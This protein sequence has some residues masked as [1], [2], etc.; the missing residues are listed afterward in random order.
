MSPWPGQWGSLVLALDVR[1]LS[2]RIVLEL[3]SLSLRIVLE[4][5]LDIR[6]VFVWSV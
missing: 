5:E 1:S 6:S 4:L 2:L 3:R